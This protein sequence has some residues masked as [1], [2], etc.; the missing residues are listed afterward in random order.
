VAIDLAI[1]AHGVAIVSRR[2]LARRIVDAAAGAGTQAIIGSIQEKYEGEGAGGQ[3]V[4]WL[5]ESGRHYGRAG[6]SGTGSRIS[7]Y[8]RSIA[9]ETKCLIVRVMT[10]M[11]MS[12]R[13]PNVKI[14]AEMVTDLEQ[15]SGSA[16]VAARE[17]SGPFNF[18]G[19][20]SAWQ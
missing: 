2:R 16:R 3:A 11:F 6:S 13:F 9:Y 19:F 8:G 4:G 12:E 14:L 1:R 17:A 18:C 7:A 10:W 20:Q 15:T 5:G